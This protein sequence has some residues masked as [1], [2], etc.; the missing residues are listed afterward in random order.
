MSENPVKKKTSKVRV[1]V[2][3]FFF[4][5]MILVLIPQITGV[6]IHEWA[7]F[8]I[9]MPFFLHLIINWE[10]I[11]ANSNKFFKKQPNKTRFDNVFNWILYLFM[12]VVTLS[13]IVISESALPLVGIHFEPDAF[14][15]KIHD[16]SATLFMALLGVH[17]ALHWKWIVGAFKKL[18]FKSDIHHLTDVKRILGTSSRQL[19]YIIV[20]SIFVSFVVYILDYSDWADSLRVTKEVTERAQNETSDGRPKTWMRYVLPMVKVTVLMTIPALI[21]GGILRLKKRIKRA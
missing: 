4:A 5:L 13:G 19:M 12:V 7:S 17:I 21:T 18:K 14:W 10:W 11:R 8:I 3:I 9:I 1:Y 6:P 2:D 20:F 15:S 16:V